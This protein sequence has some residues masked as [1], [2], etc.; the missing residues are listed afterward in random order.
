MPRDDPVIRG[1][2]LLGIR[3]PDV[4]DPGRDDDPLGAVQERLGGTEVGP[5][6]T[7]Q[8]HRPVTELL[9][10]G[11][12]RHVHRTDTPPHTDSSDPIAPTHANLTLC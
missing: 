10:G 3:R 7:A 11:D 8:P 5:R 2:E 6:R 4:D 12:E 9:G 1:G